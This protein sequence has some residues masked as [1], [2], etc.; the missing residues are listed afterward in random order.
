M[1]KES[2]YQEKIELA[3]PWLA[4]VIELVKKDLKNEHLK[5]DRD[6]CKRY[7]LGKGSNMITVAEMVEAYRKDIAEG[8]V[9]LAE[10]ITSRWILR[11][12]DIYGFFEETLA[13]LTPDFDTLQE[14]DDKLASSLVKDAISQFGAVKTYLFSLFNSVVFSDE[15]YEEMRKKA[16]SFSAEIKD[17]QEKE[18]VEKSLE[19]MQKRHTREMAALN[20]R[21]EKKL[22]GLQKKYLN[23][24]EV[25][26][27]QIRD[28]QVKLSNG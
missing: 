12:T 13:K 16:L 11:N 7:F 26:K 9:G 23:D 20:D 18:Q 17:K 25:L 28:L 15:I 22:S 4:E 1:I 8:N 27:K 21:H 5:I 2:G 14:L 10:F 3:A 19:T 6:F 24:T